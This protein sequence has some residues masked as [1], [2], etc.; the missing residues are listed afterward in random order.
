MLQKSPKY[1]AYI[2]YYLNMGRSA[3][4]RHDEY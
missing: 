2:V 3:T 1:I 4:T